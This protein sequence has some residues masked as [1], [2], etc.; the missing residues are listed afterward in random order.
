MYRTVDLKQGSPEW[1]EWRR[2]GIGASEAPIILGI[3]PYS[4]PK[5]LWMEKTGQLQPKA[6][7]S[8]VMEQGHIFES[9]VRAYME[10]M[11]TQKYSPVCVESLI[12]PFL[13]ASLD[14]FDES[15]NFIIEIKMVGRK[16]LESD[17][18]PPHHFAQFQHQMMVCGALDMLEIYGLVDEFG[19]LHKKERIVFRDAEFIKNMME[20]EIAFQ[21]KVEKK[22]EP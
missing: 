22:I 4:K 8:W 17:E 21:E 10:F 9:K 3:S 19:E 13:K 20:A 18:I 1:L 16:M 12:R 15:R 5:K 6:S 7:S 2:T 11:D 14:G